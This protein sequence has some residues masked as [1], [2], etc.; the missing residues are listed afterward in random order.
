MNKKLPYEEAFNRQMN[1]LP[2]PHEDESWQKMKMLLDKNDKRVSRAFLKKYKTLAILVFLLL[3]GI[4]LFIATKNTVKEKPVAASEK[5]YNLQQKKLT[6]DTQKKVH[7][8]LAVKQNT[9]ADTS[10]KRRNNIDHHKDQI[11]SVASNSNKILPLKK[12]FNLGKEIN[13][14]AGKSVLRG[15]RSNQN[16]NP[17]SNQITKTKAGGSPIKTIVAP[18]SNNPISLPEPLFSFPE[19]KEANDSFPNFHMNEK[20]QLSIYPKDTISIK[21]DIMNKEAIATKN[22]PSYRNKKYQLS[23][24]IG[25]QQIV[26]VGGQKAV[27]YG[28]NGIK[29]TFSDYIPSMYLR[30]ERNKQWFLQ[31]EFNYAAPQLVKEFSYNRHTK[32][33]TSGTITTA[34]L[35]LKKTFY[36]EIPISFSY[37]IHHNWSAGIGGVYS[38]F[39]GAIAEKEIMKNNMQTQTQSVVKQIVPIAGYTDSFLYKSHMYLLLQTDYNWRRLSLGLRYTQDVQPYIRYTLPDGRIDDQKNSSLKFILR[40]RLLKLAKF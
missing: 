31:G 36:H 20:D 7:Q 29:S 12:Q 9:A 10:K 13:S 23:A 11:L 33:D 40:F 28:Y 14:H 35:R 2:S 24:G 5:T 26:P 15:N 19:N 34:T 1:D 32:A 27:S 16:N 17:V 39:R 37:Y 30:L 3:T 25:V 22:T 8:P 4:G 18:T 6:D 21:D 38:L